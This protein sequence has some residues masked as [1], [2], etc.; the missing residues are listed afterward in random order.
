MI[1]F[2]EFKKIIIDESSGKMKSVFNDNTRDYLEQEH[3]SV[4]T[5]IANTLKEGNIESFCI[6]NNGVTVVADEISG[7]GDNIT[8]T[9]YQIVNGCQTSNVLYE[10]RNVVGIENMHVPL[11]IIVTNDSEIKS[12]ITRAT[13]NQTAVDAVELEALTEFQRNL[14]LF[15]DAFGKNENRLYYERRTN[16][17]KS[18]DIPMYR[19]INRETQIKV[20]A[21]MFLDKPHLVAGYYGKLTKEMGDEIFNHEHDNLPYYTSSLTYFKLENMY[22][23][24]KLDKTL[25]RFRYHLIMIFRFLVLPQTVPNFEDKRKQ[26]IY[27]NKIIEVLDNE[28]L[29]LSKFR[30]ALEFLTSDKLG[31]DFGDRK[32]PERKNTTDIILFELKN[33]FFVKN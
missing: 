19:V 10:N 23:K 2:S 28:E 17:Y 16:Q 13:N 3:N 32:T 26:E 24:N 18:S 20:F 6:L 22:N 9:N 7:P 12:Q 5:D 27:C 1:P 11:K 30:E 4:N 15:Y 29:M 25:R 8:I 31:L 14:E 21:S 33:K